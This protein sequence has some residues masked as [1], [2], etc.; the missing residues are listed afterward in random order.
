MNVYDQRDVQTGERRAT[1]LNWHRAIRQGGGTTITGDMNAHSQRWD[2]KCRKQ[3]DATVW[4]QIIDENAREIGNGDRPTHHWARNGEE[5]ESTIDFALATRPI[6][7]WTTQDWSRATHSNHEVIE[8]E[9]NIDK[10]EEADHVQ[11]IGWN[12]AAMSKQD[13][14]AAEKLWREL[15]SERAH[16]GGECTG[17][18][19]EREAKWCQE[20]LTTVLDAKENKIIIWARSKRGW[21]CKLKERRSTLGREKRRGKR[22]EAAA[23][24]KAEPQKSIR[25]SKSRRWNDSVQTLRGT[26]SGGLQGSLTLE[27]EPQWKY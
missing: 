5:G 7:G 13:K 6:T 1:K 15:E 16:L 20:S 12:L 3:Q 23:R 9:F 26:R 17:D 27:Q 18:D 22:S 14:E 11:I 19:V 24:A 4:E 25:Q 21:N 10:L 2:P 8:W